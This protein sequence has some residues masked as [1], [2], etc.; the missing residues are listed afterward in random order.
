[1]ARQIPK[2]HP[3][4]IAQGLSEGPECRMIQGA[5]MADHQGGGVLWANDPGRQIRSAKGDG[6]LGEG[7]NRRVAFDR[8][9]SMGVEI[10]R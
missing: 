5:P 9:L 7:A 8:G 6:F 3:P 2:D 1:M 4:T 10:E